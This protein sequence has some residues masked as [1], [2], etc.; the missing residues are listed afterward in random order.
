LIVVLVLLFGGG[1]GYY[2]AAPLADRQHGAA[3]WCSRE[4]LPVGRAD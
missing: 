2:C 4:P 1:A 3:A